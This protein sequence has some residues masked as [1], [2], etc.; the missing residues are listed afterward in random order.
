MSDISGSFSVAGDS[1]TNA[2]ATSAA[3]A[4]PLDGYT[5]T[6]YRDGDVVLVDAMEL[7]N[8]NNVATVPDILFYAQGLVAA[9][10]NLGLKSESGNIQFLFGGA[11]SGTTG[12]TERAVITSTGQLQIDSYFTQGANVGAVVP[13][14]MP[15]HGGSNTNY[16]ASL[17][18]FSTDVLINTN[19]Y[20]E[21]N[22]SAGGPAGVYAL[23]S[24]DG[25]GNW[26][27]YINT[28]GGPGPT[29]SANGI[30]FE[31]IVGGFSSGDALVQRSAVYG[32][33]GTAIAWRNNIVL[34][35][36]TGTSGAVGI[37]RTPTT[38][39]FEVQ[40]QAAKTT[41]GNWVNISDR[42]LKSN[43]KDFK[44]G[45]DTVLELR[46]RCFTMKGVPSQEYVGFIAQEVEA[47][48]L[49]PYAI[50]E[51]VRETTKDLP[52]TAAEDAEPTVLSETFLALKDEALVPLL[53]NAVQELAARVAS[54]EGAA[55]G[56]KVVSR[57]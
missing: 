39:D 25:T 43:V 9:E 33:A 4:A 12:A 2:W 23:R 19:L 1:D 30:A 51:W 8:A 11:G 48:S 29:R 47:T 3:L 21:F 15:I 45:L 44:L 17:A 55:A 50:T 31:R 6:A 22:S 14:S 57:G 20:L 18:Y 49:A 41:P 40:G 35:P 28:V 54:L 38:Y 24:N 13:A 26:H 52:P 42:R 56:T 32:L 53:I 36:A 46:T 7:S 37:N 16:F 34:R 10:S 27:E 5:G